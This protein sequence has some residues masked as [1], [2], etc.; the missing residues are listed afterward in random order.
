M[1]S[2]YQTKDHPIRNQF[3]LSSLHL[4]NYPYTSNVR[5]LYPISNP[6]TVLSPI[7]KNTSEGGTGGTDFIITNGSHAVKEVRVWIAKGS[8]TWSDRDL[9]KAIKVTWEDGKKSAVKGNQSNTNG[10]IFYFNDN[11]KVSDMTIR[12]G[13]RVDK[14][15]FNTTDSR[16]REGWE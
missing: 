11:E 8:G 5:L 1:N 4:K 7:V 6:N 15:I 12:T 3:A 2:I 13:D 10:Y 9:V 16:I 14:L